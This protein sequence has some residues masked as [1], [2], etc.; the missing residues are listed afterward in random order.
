MFK[1]RTKWTD[2]SISF[3]RLG[4]D[5]EDAAFMLYEYAVHRLET[6]DIENVDLYKGVTEA[7]ARRVFS[8]DMRKYNEH[9]RGTY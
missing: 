2:L 8:M 4:M 9:H 6:E 5:A 7:L 3:S 1:K